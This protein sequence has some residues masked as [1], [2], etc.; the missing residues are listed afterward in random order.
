MRVPFAFSVPRVA[1]SAPPWRRIHGTVESVSTLFTAVGMPQ[2]PLTAGKGGRD[3][4]WAR[5][6]SSDSSSAVSS[7]QMYAPW[8]R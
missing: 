8:P 5:L 6:P 1:Y 4:G 7:P 3:R 2:A